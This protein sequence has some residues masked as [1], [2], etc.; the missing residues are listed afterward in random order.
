MNFLDFNSLSMRTFYFVFTNFSQN[1]KYYQTILELNGALSITWHSKHDDLSNMSFI[2][3]VKLI[4]KKYFDNPGIRLRI[5]YEIF[6][7]DN[8]LKTFNNLFIDYSNYIEFDLLADINSKKFNYSNEQLNQFNKC[9]SQLSKPTKN[10]Y[11]VTYSNNTIKYFKFTDLI[12]NQDINF[13]Y[14]KCNAGKDCMYIH[15]D[16][17]IY[18]CESYY[19]NNQKI[20]GHINYISLINIKPQLC[21]CKWCSSCDFGI[22]KQKIFV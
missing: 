15:V 3:K 6:N 18:P 7:T 4:N 12:K 22:K 19:D 1:I 16:G 13:K 8:A 5:L 17:N 10:D 9:I 14:W 20:I 2:N 21:K 11:I